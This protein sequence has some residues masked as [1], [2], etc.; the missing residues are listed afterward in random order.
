MPFPALL[1]VERGEATTDLFFKFVGSDARKT[2]P[3]SRAAFRQLREESSEALVAAGSSR[4]ISHH[5]ANWAV[6]QHNSAW[7]AVLLDVGRCTLR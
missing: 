3:V 1:K 4:R 6:V 7:R 2:L 5:F